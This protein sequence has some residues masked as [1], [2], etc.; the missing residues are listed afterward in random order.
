VAEQAGGP[1]RVSR[2]LNATVPIYDQRVTLSTVG[3]NIRGRSSRLT[4]SYRTTQDILTRVTRI[5]A[6]GKIAYD[7]LD[8]GTET[9]DGYRSVLRG[10]APELVASDTWHDE[11]DQLT[12]TLRRWRADIAA[13]PDGAARDPRGSIAVCVSDRNKAA[14][15]ISHLTGEGVS[16]AELTKDGA[17]GDGEIHVG[18]MHRFKGL[19]YQRLAIVAA[20][21]GNLPPSWIK[22]C[23]SKTPLASRL[24]TARPVPYSLS[25]R[26]VPVTRSASAGTAPA[27][28]ICP[29]DR[30]T[31]TPVGREALLRR[32]K[33]DEFSAVLPRINQPAQRLPR[34]ILSTR[35]SRDGLPQVV[36]SPGQRIGSGV[37]GN[38]QRA[39]GQ[40][41]NTTR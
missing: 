5:V 15:V 32:R 38:P 37:H 36:P 19:E 6:P 13:G 33:A 10:S 1:G 39:T 4:L 27:V 26:P 8:D 17:I 24:R 35:A 9:L 34:L 18:T 28:P 25:L 20:S 21:D 7:D 12:D 23:S 30:L 40:F 11:L 14:D 29:N 16:C 22:H 41:L 31:P 2:S 3:V